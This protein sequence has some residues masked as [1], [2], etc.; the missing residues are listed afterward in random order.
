M[1]FVCFRW[2]VF[3]FSIVCIHSVLVSINQKCNENSEYIRGE[4]GGGFLVGEGGMTPFFLVYISW[5]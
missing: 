2:K 1:S 4:L 5:V 3:K